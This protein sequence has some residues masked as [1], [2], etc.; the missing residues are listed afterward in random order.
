MDYHFKFNPAR[1]QKEYIPIS[2][3]HDQGAS[4]KKLIVLFILAS[5]MI[6]LAGCSDGEAKVTVACPSGADPIHAQVD[7]SGWSYIGSGMQKTYTITWDGSLFSPGTETVDG[8]AEDNDLSQYNRTRSFTL[9]DGDHVT[10]TIG[11][12]PVKSS[13]DEVQKQLEQSIEIND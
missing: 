4:M 5:L 1:V 10:W 11:W 2:S 3:N 12:Y 9:E 8:T 7:D 6:T 13:G